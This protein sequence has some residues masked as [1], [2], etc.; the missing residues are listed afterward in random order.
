MF[1]S[2]GKACIPFVFNAERSEF[3]VCRRLVALFW[4]LEGNTLSALWDA[5]E[6]QKLLKF[7]RPL[8]VRFRELLRSLLKVKRSKESLISI[9]LFCSG[10]WQRKDNRGH[11]LIYVRQISIT[12]LHVIIA[13]YANPQPLCSRL[14]GLTPR[15]ATCISAFHAAWD[16][17]TCYTSS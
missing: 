9:L 1:W 13:S 17:L 6:M 11:T 14:N 16:Q 7:T 8:V 5:F 15:A 12:L 3:G 10:V 4:C 2:R